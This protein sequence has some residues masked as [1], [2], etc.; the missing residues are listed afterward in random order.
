MAVVAGMGLGVLL[1]L[2]FWSLGIIGCVV[3]S[4]AS[5]GLK[6]SVVGI[7]FLLVL[8]TVILVLWP[9]KTPEEELAGSTAKKIEVDELIIP[10]TVLFVF[11][12]IFAVVAFVFLLL[13][14]MEPIY[15]PALTSRKT[16]AF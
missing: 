15:S 8:L 4:R 2:I 9:R 1:V 12:C 6:N 3:L 16:Y 11:I 14:W 10:K 13:H 7:F 5:G